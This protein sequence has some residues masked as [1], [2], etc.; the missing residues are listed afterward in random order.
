MS[1]KNRVPCND[2]V[3]RGNVP[4]TTQDDNVPLSNYF[5]DKEDNNLLRN[6][7]R[8]IVGWTVP[9]LRQDLN[10]MKKCL[11]RNI[12]H[13]YMEKTASNSEVVS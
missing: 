5:M 10:W 6:E 12:K 13:K 8:I 7:F 4:T 11:W 9:E 1:V 3:I 2:E